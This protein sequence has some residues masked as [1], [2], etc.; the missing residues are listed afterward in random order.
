MVLGIILLVGIVAIVCTRFYYEIIRPNAFFDT[1][2]LAEYGDSVH[3]DFNKLEIKDDSQMWKF[4][5]GLKI[6]PVRVY[7]LKYNPEEYHYGSVTVGGVTSGG[8]YKTGGDYTI[9]DRSTGVYRFYYYPKPGTIAGE[10]VGRIKLTHEMYMSAK[11]SEIAKYLDDENESIKSFYHG[12]KKEVLKQI[13]Y[14][15]VNY[16]KTKDTP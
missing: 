16:K 1:T 6:E 12:T 11:Q 9:H 15:L 4:G 13:K 7:S 14:W 2:K 8:I 10:S 5:P 3:E